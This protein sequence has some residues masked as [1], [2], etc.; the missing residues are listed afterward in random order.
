[1]P[2]LLYG[3]FAITAA[4]YSMV[5]FGGGSTYIALL[6]IS[7][8]PFSII[9]VVALI[10][11]LCVVSHNVWR[12]RTEYEINKRILLPLLLTSIPFAFLGGQF[13]INKIVYFKLLGG[14][15]FLAGLSMAWKLTRANKAE[16]QLQEP[17]MPLMALIGTLFTRLFFKK[18]LF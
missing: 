18:Y 16:T 2:F 13:Q 12:Y 9:P 8:V 11:N 7:G 5:G 1:M 15:L 6:S 3:L 10:C 17:S 14:V 4:F